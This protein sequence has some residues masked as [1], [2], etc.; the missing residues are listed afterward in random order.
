MSREWLGLALEER[1]WKA[2][3]LSELEMMQP[4][5][6]RRRPKLSAQGKDSGLHDLSL[7]EASRAQ[8][9]LG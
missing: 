3:L 6:G 2:T 9:A 4:V 7:G 5:E 1:T 8:G